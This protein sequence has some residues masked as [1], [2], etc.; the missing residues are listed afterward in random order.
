MSSTFG[1]G[2]SDKREKERKERFEKR[3]N[4][5]KKSLNLYLDLAEEV[6]EER[7]ILDKKHVMTA[8][9]ILCMSDCSSDLA[10]TIAVHD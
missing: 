8:A 2:D 6:L 5:M 3:V 1:Y 9:L 4:G 7:S 10:M